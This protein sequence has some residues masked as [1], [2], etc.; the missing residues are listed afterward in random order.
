MSN[1]GPFSLEGKIALITGST[2]GIGLGIARAMQAAGAQVVVSN[3]DAAD[4]ARAAKTLGCRG[5]A[6]DVADDA[7]LA[8]LIAETVAQCGGLD[9]VVG[10]AG[11]TGAP[12][13]IAALDM[14]DYDCVMAI[15]LRA[16]VVLTKLARSHLVARGGGSIILIASLSALRGNAAISSYALAKAGV[17][18]LARNLAVEWGPHNI[19]TNAISPGLIRTE[20]S[21]PL[22]ANEAFMAKR[23]QMTPLRRVGEIDEVAGAAVFL[24]SPAG[25][26]INGH[27][28]VIDGGTRITDGN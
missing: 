28:L 15:N 17:A 16:Q 7:A 10:N 4:T 27:N 3:D 21:G 20:L 14:A 11:I 8:A 22:L 19:R 13:G 25:A 18:Q 24:A 1:P 23:L 12:G 26:F 6:A 2:R 9:I 5:I